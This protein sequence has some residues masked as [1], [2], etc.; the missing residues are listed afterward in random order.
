MAKIRITPDEL[1]SKAQEVRGKSQEHE[2]VIANITSLVNGLNAEWT[3]AAQ[4]AYVAKFQEMQP[5]FSD[6]LELLEAYAMNMDEAA[7]VLEE[8][9]GELAKVIESATA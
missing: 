1:R 3:G 2:A 8:A 4:D 5:R 9:D 6:F 7:R